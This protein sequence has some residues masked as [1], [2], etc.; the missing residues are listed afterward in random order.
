MTLQTWRFVHN[1]MCPPKMG[2][3]G[4]WKVCVFCWVALE[5]TGPLCPF[6]ETEH[7]GEG[8]D[9]RPTAVPSDACGCGCGRT[10]P[11]WRADAGA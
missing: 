5:G 4:A 8:W 2:P 11:G 10:E 3:A 7:F 1:Y 6:W 9:Q